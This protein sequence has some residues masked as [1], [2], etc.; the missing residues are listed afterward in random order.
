[1]FIIVI[2][3]MDF[4]ECFK[5]RLSVSGITSW[6]VYRCTVILHLYVEWSPPHLVNICSTLAVG[7]RSFK[8]EIC[9]I[10]MIHKVFYKFQIQ[11]CDKCNETHVFQRWLG[12]PVYIRYMWKNNFKQLWATHQLYANN[13]LFH[14]L[15]LTLPR[16]KETSLSNYS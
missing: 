11:H 9:F 16:K 14:M 10:V 3:L 1:M 6:H 4:V 15:G 12:S 8:K 13:I 2:K 5:Y 7:F